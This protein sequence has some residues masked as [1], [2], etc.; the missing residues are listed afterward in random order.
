MAARQRPG[1]AVWAARGAARA[2][3]FPLHHCTAPLWH[4][5]KQCVVLGNAAP[6][7]VRPGRSAAV[8]RDVAGFCAGYR[9][10]GLM[11]LH[12]EHADD[13]C[14]PRACPLHSRRPGSA[15]RHSHDHRGVDAGGS[16]RLH[17]V[18]RQREPALG[19]PHVERVFRLRLSAG[20]GAWR[21]DY[22]DHGR[23]RAGDLSSGAGFECQRGVQRRARRRHRS[24][25]RDRRTQ[26]TP[27]A[28]RTSI[29]GRH[30]AALRHRLLRQ[31]RIGRPARFHGDRPR[32]ELDKPHRAAVPRAR[33]PPDPVG[34]LR[35]GARPADV[36]IGRV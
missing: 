7:R 25:G 20:A 31:Y 11:A 21:R 18:V 36:G 34:S 33:S 23:R 13:L 17:A 19:D 29:A 15:R 26:Q 6:G 1:I 14:R 35:R 12:R 30:R 27:P 16:A 3:L 9:S 2:G 28:R 5:Y 22:G 8:R 32:C 24:L 10:Q 4:G